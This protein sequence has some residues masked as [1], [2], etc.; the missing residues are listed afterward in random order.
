MPRVQLKRKK[1]KG[2]NQRWTLQEAREGAGVWGEG[3]EETREDQEREASVGKG[4]GQERRGLG[5]SLQH[6]VW[7]FLGSGPSSEEGDG[8]VEGVIRLTLGPCP[9]E[10]PAE[11]QQGDGEQPP[12]QLHPPS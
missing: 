7:S 5:G 4:G 12:G 3:G 6:R 9:P 11:H 1:K 8:G 2:H 10:P